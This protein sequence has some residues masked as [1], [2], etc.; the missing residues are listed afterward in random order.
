MKITKAHTKA[1]RE[2]IS[3]ADYGARAQ[4]FIVTVDNWTS[5]RGR[6]T[7]PRVLPPGVRKI[8]LATLQ[9]QRQ[10]Q[11][12]TGEEFDYLNYFASCNP[13]RKYILI[14]P[15]SEYEKVIYSHGAG[16]DYAQDIR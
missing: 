10:Q 5:G 4:L 1:L 9:Q 8:E 7:S 13:R 14:L 16:L 3:V 12:L 6:F 11:K 2:F 15:L